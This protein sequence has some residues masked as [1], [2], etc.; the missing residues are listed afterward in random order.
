MWS[1]DA[2]V[3]EFRRSRQ[4]AY[5]ALARDV[6]QAVKRTG[7]TRRPRRTR[8]PAIRR[9]LEIFRER[10]TG[11]EAID[12]F[13]SAGRDRAVALL[14]ELARKADPMP[15]NTTPSR[16]S[17]DPA[18]FTARVWVTRPRPGVD[19]MSSAWLIRRFIDPQARFDFAI[20]KD[21][22]PEGSVPF[23]MFGVDFSHQ[24]GGCTF[25][26]LCS[27]FAIQDPPVSRIATI[28]HDLDLKDGKFGA[29]ECSTVG[30]A[31]EGLRLAFEDDDVL[32]AQGMTLFDALFRS[33]EQSA[34]S[35]GPRAVASPKA[36]AR[37]RKKP[38]GEG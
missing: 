28:V 36:K 17:N 6:E 19:R 13:G 4:E 30:A 20:D 15:V 9:L 11:I 16:S 8:A 1:D 7:S 12:F 14:D 10:L 21:A 37:E 31:I 23:D 3:E 34:R 18:A 33:F 32:L 5:A 24:G 27:V 38:R 26:T 22:V 2:L 25:E 35:S 29:P